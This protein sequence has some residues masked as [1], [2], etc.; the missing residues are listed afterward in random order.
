MP[1]P[2]SSPTSRLAAVF[3]TVLGLGLVWGLVWANLPTK[4][5]L[6]AAPR[7]AVPP[8]EPALDLSIPGVPSKQERTAPQVIVNG[9]G[10]SSA[11]RAGSWEEIRTKQVAEMK[12]EAD[13]Q[14]SCPEDLPDDERRRCMEQRAKRVPAACQAMIRQRLVRWKESTGD[15]PA[16]AEDAKQFCADLPPGDGR[17]LQCLQDHAQDVSDRCYAA[18]PKGALTLNH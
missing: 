17:V 5:D 11:P 10:V 3:T 18:L 4:D 8:P 7:A 16:C 13:L 9:A 15:L 6:D 1:K 12:C 2:S 14:Q